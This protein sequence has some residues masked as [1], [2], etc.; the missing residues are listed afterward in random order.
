MYLRFQFLYSLILCLKNA[1]EI[2]GKTAVLSHECFG[3]CK[4]KSWIIDTSYAKMLE[5][6]AFLMDLFVFLGN[7]AV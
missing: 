1:L 3:L 5:Q 2:L 7:Q 4:K 6:M